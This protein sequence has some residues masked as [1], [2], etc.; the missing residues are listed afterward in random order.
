MR[1]TVLMSDHI[2]L[3]FVLVSSFSY[4]SPLVLSISFLSI[5]LIAIM[6]T[7]RHTYRLEKEGYAEEL[8]AE[9]ERDR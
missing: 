4:T 5:S 7:L 2:C 1:T 8:S 9:R 3:V 6:L